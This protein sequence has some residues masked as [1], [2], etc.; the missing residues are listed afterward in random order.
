MVTCSIFFVFGVLLSQDVFE[1]VTMTDVSHLFVIFLFCRA[2][3]DEVE[4]E[5]VEIEAKLDKVRS[6]ISTISEGNHDFISERPNTSDLA[7]I[8]SKPER[9]DGPQCGSRQSLFKEHPPVLSVSCTEA[10]IILIESWKVIQITDLKA[11]VTAMP[12]AALGKHMWIDLSGQ[13]PDH[14]DGISSG[15]ITD[16]GHW[17]R[18]RGEIIIMR[19][20]KLERDVVSAAADEMNTSLDFILS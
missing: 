1:G 16:M 14:L 2:N 6:T 10:V 17:I 20:T 8:P 12:C 19:A 11:L 9:D 4:T 15:G 13:S 18:T 3:I 7:L 5:V